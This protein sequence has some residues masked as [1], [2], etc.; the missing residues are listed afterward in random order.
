[1]SAAVRDFGIRAA[2]RGSR[3]GV[4]QFSDGEHSLTLT[5]SPKPWVWGTP[6]SEARD[7]LCGEWNGSLLSLALYE[8]ETAVVACTTD[9]EAFLRNVKGLLAPPTAQDDEAADE[10]AEAWASDSDQ[11]LLFDLTL[12][13]R[14][15]PHGKPFNVTVN[16]DSEMWKET[17]ALLRLAAWTSKH[18]H[19]DFLSAPGDDAGTAAPASA[20]TPGRQADLFALFLAQ[21]ELVREV[22]RRLRDIRRGY[23]VHTE[24]L[25]VVRG[26]ITARGLGLHLASGL[27]AL[28]CT[29]DRFT[30]A[31][32]L[33]RVLV[34]ALD[35]IAGG[36]LVRRLQI[37]GWTPATQLME[38]AR[39]YRRY[40][41]P[42]PSLSVPVASAAADRLRVRGTERVWA[43]ALGRARQ[44]LG[45]RPPER[46][47]HTD[48]EPVGLIWWMETNKVWE[49]ILFRA[50][51]QL[52]PQAARERSQ[53]LQTWEG[54]GG[55]S[56]TD[57][58][59]T[60]PA[61]EE[62]RLDATRMVL[63]AKYKYPKSTPDRPDQAQMFAYSFLADCGG[64]P[65]QSA[66][67]VYPGRPEQADE[68]VR[69]EGFKRG[70]RNASDESTV[71]LYLLRLAF[72]GRKTKNWGAYVAAR[73]ET[74]RT[75]RAS[76]M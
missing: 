66:A 47:S 25:G 39:R 61:L 54:L 52:D 42:I 43:A 31:T 26:R 5:V 18:S 14:K 46:R 22:G 28:E 6:R 24:V 27:P 38:E 9:Q 76:P 62:P 20:N 3:S 64:A 70:R 23:V 4:A 44:I 34:T 72:P 48:G 8:N 71:E 15:K 35:V 50:A 40:L 21:W 60:L 12:P 45:F 2:P 59:A 73:A 33:F 55:Q 17:Q 7:G 63:D 68:L 36:A 10:G 11:H 37:A 32:T 49:E 16:S 65:A 19:F 56:R 58:T 1:M 75:F 67:L 74:L 69:A 41:S 13:R 53:A 51:C 29:F 30:E 57:V